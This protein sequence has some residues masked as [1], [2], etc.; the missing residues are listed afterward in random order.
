MTS[1]LCRLSALLL[2]AAGVTVR[3]EAATARPGSP[4]ILFILAEDIGPDLSCYG[5]PL[6]KTPNLDA[7]AARGVRYQN[8]FTTAPVCSTSRTAMMT[9]MY[10]TSIGAHN[11]R[12][13]QWNKKPLPPGVRTIT[14]YF[15]DAGYFT[16]NLSAG[17]RGEKGKQGGAA[18]PTPGASGAGKTDF[19]FLVEK[20]FDGNDWNQRAAGQPFFAQITI[21]ESHKGAGWPLA[22]KVLGDRCI[23]PAKVKL[24][25]YYPDHPVARDEYA[26][27][28]DAIMLVDGFVGELLARLAKDGLADNTIV[29]FIGDNGQCLFRSKQFLYD[30]GI[31]IPLLIA[32]PDKRRAGQVDERMVSSIDLSATMLGMAG[33]TPGPVM[34][35]RNFLDPAVAPREHVFAARDRMD[36]ST[37]K[38]RAVRTSRWKYIRN[39][40]P[41][42]PY[43]QHNAYKEAQYPTWNLVKQLA[44][45][46]KL[47]PEAALFAADRKPI[48][49]LFDLS[50]DPYEVKN[51]AANP[52]QADTLKKMRALVDEWVVSTGDQGTFIEDPLEIQRGYGGPAGA[53]GAAK[54]KKKA[55]G[56]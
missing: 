39:Y 33:I 29:I 7:L 15:R 56:E 24:P 25:P 48:E 20:P 17:N 51:L 12:T 44:K 53:P 26:N 43:M 50:A 27:Y 18:G 55:G 45:E 10:Q 28:L 23:D 21:T 13:W 35:G 2:L 40:F 49:E 31:H 3:L 46:G 4:N 47:T 19:N 16:C 30:G 54:G 22:R 9:G 5:T 1:L 14:D 32:W 36:M 52:E 38:M 34:Q 42:I 11:H 41:M 8:C 6:I 37:D